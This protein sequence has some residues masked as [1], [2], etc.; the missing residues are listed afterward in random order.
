MEEN[1]C[2]QSLISLILVVGVV[3]Q[4]FLMHYG[5]DILDGQDI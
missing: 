1:I 3:K 5:C 4:H 2:K